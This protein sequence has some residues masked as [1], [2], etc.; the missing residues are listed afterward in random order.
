MSE[1]NEVVLLEGI[2]YMI[3]SYDPEIKGYYVGSTLQ[4]FSKRNS[5]HKSSCNNNKFKDYNQ[6]KY[7]YI[8][9]NGGWLNFKMT[10][11]DR[12]MVESKEELRMIEQ[13]WIDTIKPNL[14]KNKSYRTVE[15]SKQY[16]YNRYRTDEYKSDRKQ[17][18][19][20]GHCDK[21]YTKRAKSTHQKT[22]YCKNYNTTSESSTE[23]FI[24]SDTESN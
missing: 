16:D 10:I 12:V 17:V 21:T 13:D 24:E 15:E 2:I 9:S 8:R 6:Y 18:I 19:Q 23:S 11:I 22:K 4:T 20:C 1:Q 14:N 3:D 7:V 5:E